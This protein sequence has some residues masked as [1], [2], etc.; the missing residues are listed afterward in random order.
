[1]ENKDTCTHS[2]NLNKP[3]IKNREVVWKSI[4]TILWSNP[5]EEWKESK[6]ILWEQELIK[7]VKRY[8]ELKQGKENVQKEEWKSFNYH[9]LNVKDFRKNNIPKNIHKL[10]G[11]SS[12]LIVL[13]NNLYFLIAHCRKTHVK[14]HY[15]DFQ[16]NEIKFI[17][18]QRWEV[19]SYS[20]SIIVKSPQVQV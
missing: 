19:N 8:W 17:N 4:V 15:V 5:S 11:N 10:S 9:K 12:H 7:I 3:S 18:H 16:G 20:T 1:M 6:I 13:G 2:W 14:W